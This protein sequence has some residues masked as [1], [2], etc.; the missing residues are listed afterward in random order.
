MFKNNGFIDCWGKSTH[1]GTSPTDI[2]NVKDIF[3][4]PDTFTA[5]LNNNNLITWGNTSGGTPIIKT[6]QKLKKQALL[7]KVNSLSGNINNVLNNNTKLTKNYIKNNDSVLANINQI[8][9]KKVL[10]FIETLRRFI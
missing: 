4:T 3:S 6:N 5:L 1:G 8:V 7:N 9:D 10:N 2:S